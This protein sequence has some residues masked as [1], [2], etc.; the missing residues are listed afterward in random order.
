MCQLFGVMGLVGLAESSDAQFEVDFVHSFLKSDRLTKTPRLARAEDDWVEKTA[1]LDQPKQIGVG[2]IVENWSSHKLE[3]PEE[4]ISQG[5]AYKH[6]YYSQEVDKYTKD[7]GLLALGRK[8]HTQGTLSYLIE[9]IW[10]RTFITVGWKF[11][12]SDLEVV[13]SFNDKHLEYDQLMEK[14]VSGMQMSHKMRYYKA[15]ER[16]VLALTCMGR[17]NTRTLTLSLVLQKMDVWA[18]EQHYKNKDNKQSLQKVSVEPEEEVHMTDIPMV[19][20]PRVNMDEE[21][22]TRPFERKELLTKG[23]SVFSQ[24]N[25]TDRE[26]VARLKGSVAVGI[27]IENWSK[28]SLNNPKVVMESGKQSSQFRVKQVEPGYVEFE[29]LVQDGILTGVS[30]VIYWNIGDTDK[31]LSLMVSVPYNPQLYSAWVATGITAA[32]SVPDFNA[33]YSG[34]PDSSWFIR[35]QTGRKGEF[36]DG[37]LI[38]VVDSDGGTSK[39]VVRLAVVPRSDDGVADVVNDRLEGKEEL[40]RTGGME[41]DRSVVSALSSSAQCMCP[42]N[43]SAMCFSRVIML[44]A[45]MLHLP[46]AAQIVKFM[47]SL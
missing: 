33:M 41:G 36:T 10:P 39:P 34:T 26:M 11:D 47:P 7:M 40:Q 35:H 14:E 31:T 4:S 12:G 44:I 28:H 15:N 6:S 38:L 13:M 37:D 3:F 23:E 43:G 30:A 42:C 29:A 20:K 45:L 9:D 27:R 2:I 21:E 32:A 18:W 19:R 24:G 1:A 22:A 46:Y 5:R 25:K 17:G 8:G 16:F